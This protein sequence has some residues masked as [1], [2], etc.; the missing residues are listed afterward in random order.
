MQS[1]LTQEQQHEL[2][3]AEVYWVAKAMQE[4]G[5]RFFRALGL[6]LE[7]ADLTNRR[8]IYATWSL[9]CWDFYQR[10][11]VLAQ[12]EEASQES[13]ASIAL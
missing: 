3:D 9:E 10:G 8:T 2:R 11:K 1:P 13:R 4:Q 6:A 12:K 5:S 7:A